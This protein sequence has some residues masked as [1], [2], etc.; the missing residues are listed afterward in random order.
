MELKKLIKCEGF[1][2]RVLTDKKIEIPE[3]V[4]NFIDPIISKYDTM[5]NGELKAITH[6]TDSYKITTKNE[7]IMGS[8][9]DKSLASLETFFDENN[10]ERTSEITGENLPKFSD[11]D[12]IPYEL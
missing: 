4:A 7:R 6:A 1:N 10:G 11:A 5:T 2:I 12:L 3:E 9:I 8:L